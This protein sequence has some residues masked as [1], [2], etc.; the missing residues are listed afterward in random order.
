[1]AQAI[2]SAE[3]PVGG[4]NTGAICISMRP[5]S[6]LGAAGYLA[7]ER[8]APFFDRLRSG[9]RDSARASRQP[10]RHHAPDHSGMHLALDP[11]SAGRV[12]FMGDLTHGDA[13][14]RA[15][16][17]GGELQ[18]EV[19]V[20]CLRPDFCRCASR[21]CPGR[22]QISEDY[23]RPGKTGWGHLNP[24]REPRESARDRCRTYSFFDPKLIGEI[25]YRNPDEGVCVCAVCGTG[26]TLAS[27]A[28]IGGW[29][30]RAP[31]YSE[32]IA[33]PRLDKLRRGA[34][35]RQGKERV[36][37]RQRC[38]ASRPSGGYAGP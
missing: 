28:W 1:M 33:A 12:F 26:P 29:T 36:A 6:D 15:D 10:H 2:S 18:G 38:C 5:A 22:A 25:T 21:D 35:A 17:C 14:Q 31:V 9:R 13:V 20:V 16:L 27:K 19:S 7:P 3:Q 34:Q 8:C 30:A 4:G 24:G 32:A 37:P 11:S 23:R